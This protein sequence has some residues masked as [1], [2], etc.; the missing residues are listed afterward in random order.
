[1][2]SNS[3]ILESF[4][5]HRPQKISGLCYCYCVP[6]TLF[7]EVT[8]KDPIRE[9]DFL[10]PPLLSILTKVATETNQIAFRFIIYPRIPFS[11]H[12][13]TKVQYPHFHLL[14]KLLNDS[15][16]KPTLMHSTLAAGRLVGDRQKTY[17]ESVA[18]NS[19]KTRYV[20]CFNSNHF[21]IHCHQPHFV[22]SCSFMFF[23]DR[24]VESTWDLLLAQRERSTWLNFAQFWNNFAWNSSKL[25]KTSS[26]T[27]QECS[28][29]QYISSRVKRKINKWEN[30]KNMQKTCRMRRPHNIN[31]NHA[32]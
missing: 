10:G 14:F 23:L 5:V 18:P 26:K 25:L 32:H 30:C 7:W 1:M 3:K 24:T 28:I 15:W 11:W 9:Y 4:L 8:Q 20:A 29:S 21:H 6:L 2:L 13:L 12:V 16:Q 31:T 17:R 22:S 19:A 27:A